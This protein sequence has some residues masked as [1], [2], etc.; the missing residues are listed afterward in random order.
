MMNRKQVLAKKMKDKR[1]SLQTSDKKRMD[2]KIVA[3]MAELL[4]GHHTIALFMPLKEEVNILPLFDAYRH[5]Y[6][7]VFP[8]VISD[9]AMVFYHVESY[10][11]FEQGAFNLLEPK[12]TCQR[13]AKEEIDLFFIPLL[14]YNDRRHRIGYGK[15]YYDRYLQNTTAMKY[16]VAYSFQKVLDRF[17]DEHDVP[18]DGIISERGFE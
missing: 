14:V 13:V 7:F 11:D 6:R 5:A 16:G 18:C 12:R 3:R 4:E 10:D 17:E 9:H 15:G 2:G 1:A 8:K